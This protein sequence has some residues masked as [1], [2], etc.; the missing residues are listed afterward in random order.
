MGKGQVDFGDESSEG[1][2]QCDGIAETA[3]NVTVSDMLTRLRRYLSVID[4]R[5]QCSLSTLTSK[6]VYPTMYGCRLRKSLINAFPVP[7]LS[8]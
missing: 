2:A 5:M 8:L 3:E 4:R 7:C 6:I 1:S